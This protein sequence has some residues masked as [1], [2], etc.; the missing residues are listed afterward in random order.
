MAAAG[1]ADEDAGRAHR[2]G[3]LPRSIGPR[4]AVHRD[5]AGLRPAAPR[6]RPAGH[7]PRLPGGRNRRGLARR[8]RRGP[9]DAVP[10][11][12]RLRGGP[13]RLGAARR[14]P[15]R[16][17]WCGSDR[18]P[19]VDPQPAQQGAAGAGGLCRAEPARPVPHGLSAGGCLGAAVDGLRAG[20]GRCRRHA[21]LGDLR[22]AQRRG[23]DAPVPAAARRATAAAGTSARSSGVRRSELRECPSADTAAAHPLRRR[24]PA[25]SAA[26]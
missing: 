16:R 22:R 23:A 25:W 8:P 14:W 18:G 5:V 21:D 13:A 19:R 3:R 6:P 26:R 11:V 24:G 2:G 7:Q 15:G 1:A 12:R 9:N 4:S 10:P 20:P 17:R